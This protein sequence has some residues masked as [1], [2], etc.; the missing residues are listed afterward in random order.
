MAFNTLI[1]IQEAYIDRR[2]VIEQMP[3]RG[4]KYSRR[5][6]AAGR[7]ARRAL[8]ARGYSEMAAKLLIRDAEDM[9]ALELAADCEE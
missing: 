5:R 9:V 6:G 7:D 2:L 4:I 3:T 8:L 1:E